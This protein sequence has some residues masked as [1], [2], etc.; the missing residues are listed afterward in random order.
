MAFLLG[1]L[2]YNRGVQ[3]TVRVMWAVPSWCKSQS[4]S[5]RGAEVRRRCAHMAGGARGRRGDAVGRPRHGDRGGW[6]RG[7][8]KTGPGGRRGGGRLGLCFALR[9]SST[10]ACKRTPSITPGTATALSP[11]EAQKSLQVRATM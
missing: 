2:T 4:A 8:H 1:R 11:F 9:C 7:K 6:A 10:P 3:K 5:E